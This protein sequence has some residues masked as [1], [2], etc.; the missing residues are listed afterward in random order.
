MTAEEYRTFVNWVCLRN[1]PQTAA[2]LIEER[3]REPLPERL[4]RDPVVVPQR[5][6]GDGAA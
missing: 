1:D 4:T 5:A 6:E 2:R 3:C